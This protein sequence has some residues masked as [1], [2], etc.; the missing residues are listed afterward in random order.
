MK[1]NFRLLLIVILTSLITLQGKA[2]KPVAEIIA[3]TN[4]NLSVS[5][6]TSTAGGKYAPRNLVAIWVEDNNGVF[7]K[8]LLVNAK[9]QIKYLTN[10]LT[11]N[12]EGNSVDALTGATVNS[13]NTLTATWNGTDIAGIVVNNGTYRLCMELSD[14]DDTGNFSYFTFTKGAT[15]DKQTPTDKPSFSNITFSWTPK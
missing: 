9:R 6:T 15:V 14:M 4:G 7:V 5:V 11:K 3:K 13:Y 1:M 10:W 12:P 8:T 2:I